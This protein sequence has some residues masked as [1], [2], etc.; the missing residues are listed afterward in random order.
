[1]PDTWEK[2]HGLDPN[3]ASDGSIVSL[4]AD[5]YTNV[6]MYLN[7]LAGD[8]VEYNGAPARSA[9]ENFEAEDYSSESGT[10]NENQ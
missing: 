7:E 2:E 4:S 6:E 3:D 10:K 9:F 5:D 8:P 1:M